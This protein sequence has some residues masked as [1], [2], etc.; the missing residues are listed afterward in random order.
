MGLVVLAVGGTQIEL[1]MPLPPR[2]I[3]T[4]AGSCFDGKI[5]PLLGYGIRG[6]VWYQGESNAR[7]PEQGMLYAKQLPKLIGE[8]RQRWGQGDFPFAWVQLPN[9]SGQGFEGW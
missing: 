1:W 5:A 3:Q 6:A 9:F 4:G 2:R 8:W 7:T